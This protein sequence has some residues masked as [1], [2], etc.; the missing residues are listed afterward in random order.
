MIKHRQ[1][2]ANL[3]QFSAGRKSGNFQTSPDEEL[4]QHE[5]SPDEILHLILCGH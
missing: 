3:P 2:P 1:K 4:N 5:P